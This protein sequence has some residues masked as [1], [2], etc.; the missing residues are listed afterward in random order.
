MHAQLGYGLVIDLTSLK[1]SIFPLMKSCVELAMCYGSL[2]CSMM[3]FLQI[4]LDAF[5]TSK[6]FL[7]TSKFNLL[8]SS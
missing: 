1:S 3:E 6:I 7:M 4:S 2:S 8:L 5:F